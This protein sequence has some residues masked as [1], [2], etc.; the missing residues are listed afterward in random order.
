MIEYQEYQQVQLYVVVP[1]YQCQDDTDR[2]IHQGQHKFQSN[3]IGKMLGQQK[4]MLGN[5]PVVVAGD[6]HI[7]QDV[8]NHRKTEKRKIQPVA[9]IAYQVLNCPVYP[10]NPE[11]LDQQIQEKQQ[12]EVCNKFTFQYRLVNSCFLAS[13]F[14]M[15]K[16]KNI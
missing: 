6:T 10:K 3:N 5:I 13:Q 11:W 15:I 7:E 1:D 4:L 8:E 2:R 9:L 16:L 14:E 12:Y